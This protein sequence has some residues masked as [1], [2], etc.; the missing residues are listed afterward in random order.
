[1]ER[2]LESCPLPPHAHNDKNNPTVKGTHANT[3]A[4][5]GEG[6]GVLCSLCTA[7][8]ED[9]PRAVTVWELTVPE[10]EL[11]PSCPLLEAGPTGSSPTKMDVPFLGLMLGKTEAHTAL[12]VLFA[13]LLLAVCSLAFL[14]YK[15]CKR[16]KQRETQPSQH[17]LSPISSF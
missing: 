16:S 15:Y 14:S 1:M 13:L 9:F 7:G 10:P 2:T 3:T 8:L 11:S 5:W 17:N 6:W 12:Y 4:R